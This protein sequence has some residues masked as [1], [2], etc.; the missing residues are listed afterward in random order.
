M[1]SQRQSLT[2]RL[3]DITGVESDEFIDG[4]MHRLIETEEGRAVKRERDKRQSLEMDSENV[5]RQ[6]ITH[7]VLRYSESH[8]VDRLRSSI[9]I[10]DE[11]R[12][13]KLLDLS[14]L[15]EAELG[16]ALEATERENVISI[17]GADPLMKET[18]QRILT[19]M[20]DGQADEKIFGGLKKVTEE[21]GE[22]VEDEML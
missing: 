7:S 21:C 15:F 16:M 19:R 17:R 18:S 13:Q 20:L 12:R 14:Q 6:L 11:G 8:S 9:R 22:I 2:D 10:D 1:A 3:I 5:A 4:L